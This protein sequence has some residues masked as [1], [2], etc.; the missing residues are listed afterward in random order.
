[1]SRIL[2]IEAKPLEE[3][4]ILG[5][6]AGWVH[7]ESDE[8]EFDLDS[9]AGFGSTGLSMSV[10]FADGTRVTE[11]ATITELA[12]QWANALLAEHKKGS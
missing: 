3:N 4:H 2:T 11:V 7:G 6:R 9:G 5:L 1:M 12:K 8:L 10:T